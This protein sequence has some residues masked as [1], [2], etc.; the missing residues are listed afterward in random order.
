MSELTDHWEHSNC[1]GVVVFDLS[2]GFC[3]RCHEENLEAVVRDLPAEEA[4][5]CAHPFCVT[6]IRR[7]RR[8]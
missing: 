6:L 3:T 7:E 4:P 8:G 1:G 5:A 2:G